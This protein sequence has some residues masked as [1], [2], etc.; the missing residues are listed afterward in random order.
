MERCY[1]ELRESRTEAAVD[2]AAALFSFLL[3]GLRRRWHASLSV[4]FVADRR[5]WR[6]GFHRGLTVSDPDGSCAKRS[7]PQTAHRR[8]VRTLCSHL[9]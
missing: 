1:R 5:L 4:D 2:V 3:D 6:D 8:A 9:P 7:A